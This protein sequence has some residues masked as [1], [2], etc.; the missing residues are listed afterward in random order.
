LKCY[1]QNNT[2]I[3]YVSM[4]KKNFQY[5]CAI[6]FQQHFQMKGSTSYLIKQCFWYPNH[7]L[8]PHL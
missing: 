8:T 7:A 2:L 1:A 5:E 3:M 4:K 6:K